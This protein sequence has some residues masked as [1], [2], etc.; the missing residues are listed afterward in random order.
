MDAGLPGFAGILSE[1]PDTHEVKVKSEK[2]SATPKDVLAREKWAK[3]F[4][5][6]NREAGPTT[7]MKAVRKKFGK[8]LEFYRARNLING[9]AEKAVTRPVREP[10]VSEPHNPKLLAGWW[11]RTIQPL[12]ES[13]GI[14][15]VVWKNGKVEVTVTSTIAF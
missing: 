11:T 6:K 10:E 8:G 15:G 2:K 14:S 4:I 12:L 5:K 13:Q 3:E 7:V 9:N 1:T